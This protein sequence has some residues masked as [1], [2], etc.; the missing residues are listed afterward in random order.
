MKWRPQPRQNTSRPRNSSTKGTGDWQCGHKEMSITIPP[1]PL[2]NMSG[3]AF[4]ESVG[5][6][7]LTS[8]ASP[9]ACFG[10]VESVFVLG[11]EDSAQAMTDRGTVIPLVRYEAA[12]TP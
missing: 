2:P 3:F 7:V 11:V 12:I 10:V 8:Q 5:M 4:D 9:E 1:R 6:P